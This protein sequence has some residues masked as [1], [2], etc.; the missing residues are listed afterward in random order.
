MVTSCVT[1][2]A[3]KLKLED[4]FDSRVERARLACSIYEKVELVEKSFFCKNCT[5][6]LSYRAIF[7][8]KKTVYKCKQCV[9]FFLSNADLQKHVKTH[10]LDSSHVPS[11]QMLS[12]I[13][14]LKTVDYYNPN[15]FIKALPL[16]NLIKEYLLTSKS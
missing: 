14:I 1:C 8:V 9:S 16:P 10:L 13:S 12:K 4:A 7:V 3:K 2:T 6:K 15:D 5:N 11:L